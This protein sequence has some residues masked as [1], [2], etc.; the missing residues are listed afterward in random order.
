MW[1][2]EKQMKKY[3][4][5]NSDRIRKKI[6][7]NRDENPYYILAF[8]GYYFDEI[9]ICYVEDNGYRV[10]AWGDRNN[11]FGW[12]FFSDFSFR[13]DIKDLEHKKKS[14]YLDKEVLQILQNVI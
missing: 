14:T 2:T 6:T 3:I 1:P 11:K 10:I 9:T 8:T 5:E 12:M 4:I 13:V 7:D